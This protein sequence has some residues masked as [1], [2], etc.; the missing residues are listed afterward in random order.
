MTGHISAVA[1]VISGNELH[2]LRNSATAAPPHPKA[3]VSTHAAL[4]KTQKTIA[5]SAT[6]PVIFAIRID[7]ISDHILAR[8]AAKAPDRSHSR[9]LPARERFVRL[10]KLKEGP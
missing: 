1:I 8:M 2:P 10:N 9:R 6:R 3:S 7:M 5:G 4:Y